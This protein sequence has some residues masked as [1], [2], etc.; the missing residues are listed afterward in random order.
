MSFIRYKVINNKTY[1]Y[2]V[3]SYWD[4]KLKR[5][6]SKSKYLG[7]VDL[8]KNEIKKFLKKSLAADKLVLDFGDAYFLQKFIESSDLYKALKKN[9]FDKN[10]ALIPL[11]IY[12]LCTQSAMYHCE[13]WLDGSVLQ[14]LHKDINLSSQRLS[15]FFAS[16][17]DEALQQNFFKQYLSLTGGR[18]KSVIIDAT[19]LPNS[20]Q[21]DFNEWGRSNGKIE[22]QFRMLCV[23]DQGASLRPTTLA[24]GLRSTH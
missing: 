8:K 12:R 16:I 17:G 5:S 9:F 7:P 13:E 1:A 21:I 22:K 3:T 4:K 2:E 23:V 19:S 18:N 24:E 11:I 6:K 20:I 14:Y 10:F 15:E